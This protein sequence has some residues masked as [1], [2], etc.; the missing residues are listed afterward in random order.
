MGHGSPLLRCRS[1]TFQ[2]D[3]PKLDLHVLERYRRKLRPQVGSR[4]DHALQGSLPVPFART[5]HS[6]AF[7]KVA[8]NI[9]CSCSSLPMVGTDL[10]SRRQELRV[11]RV[12]AS[13]PIT[14]RN[15][16]GAAA[17]AIASGTFPNPPSS[18]YAAIAQLDSNDASADQQ[19]QL[20]PVCAMASTRSCFS[21]DQH[22]C[23]NHVYSC[24]ECGDQYCGECFDAHHANG[25]WG[26]SD[27]AVELAQ[28]R[29]I[30]SSQC[31]SQSVLG[32]SSIVADNESSG[33][34]SHTSRLPTFRSLLTF[35]LQPE[36]CW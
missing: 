24:S 26:D 14:F 23:S 35:L 31:S 13:G 19:P 25:H 34:S 1:A 8:P 5:F 20:C 36:A 11:N 7:P 10:S 22:F 16:I 30:H 21:C 2:P 18:S 4:P 6:R 12:S 28:A 17:L 33:R 9:S 3:P 29:Y 15:P 32:R 27:T